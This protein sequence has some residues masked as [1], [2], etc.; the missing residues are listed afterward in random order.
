AHEL[1]RVLRQRAQLAIDV[2]EA[3]ARAGRRLLDR[4]AERVAECEC[5]ARGPAEKRAGRVLAYEALAA[6]GAEATAGAW[7]GFEHLRV[8]SG[9]NQR[10]RDRQ[11][12]QSTAN[13]RDAHLGGGRELADGGD[14]GAHVIRVGL[15]QHAVPEVEDVPDLPGTREDLG[16]AP[17]DLR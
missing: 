2:D 17:A 9:G 6:T 1:D 4:Y 15:G 12:T 3:A 8:D 11:P 10:A 5:A 7:R 16:D 14:H 13:D